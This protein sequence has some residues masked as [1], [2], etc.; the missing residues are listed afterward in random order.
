MPATA[1]IFFDFPATVGSACVGLDN[2]VVGF[3]IDPEL[4]AT[5]SQ[6]RPLADRIGLLSTGAPWTP[7]RIR[8]T[9][10]DNDALALFDTDLILDSGFGAAVAASGGDAD[11]CVFVSTDRERRKRAAAAGMLVTPHAVLARALLNGDRL[12]HVRISAPDDA[13]V[14]SL[15]ERVG[16]A[17]AV[18]FH[19]SGEPRP[20]L[21]ALASDEAI[22]EMRTGGL[23]VVALGTPD[24]VET[25]DLYIFRPGRTDAAALSE[26]RDRI[27][28]TASLFHEIDEDWLVGLRAGVD[29]ED[30]HPPCAPHGH[31]LGLQPSR[32]LIPLRAPA[33]AL[34]QRNLSGDEL[35]DLRT[36][37]AGLIQ[38]YLAPWYGGPIHSRH[39][40]HEDNRTAALEMYAR[41]EGILGVGAARTCEF[42]HHYRQLLNVEGE[43]RGKTAPQEVVLVGA[44]LDSTAMDTSGYKAAISAAPGADDDASGVAAVLAIADVLSKMATAHLPR[45]T[46]RF[47]LFNAE[48]VFMG[49][50]FDYARRMKKDPAVQLLAMLQLDMIG[51]RGASTAFE[52]HAMGAKD[53]GGLAKSVVDRSLEL[54]GIVRKA[55]GELCATFEPQMYPMP[56]CETDP[57]HWRSDHRQFLV[58]GWPACLVAEDLFSEIAC[59]TQA[60]NPNYHTDQDLDVDPDYAAEIA[61]AVAG[62]VWMVANG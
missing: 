49:G 3:A 35:K 29:A 24:L 59:G 44:H 14:V 39:A 61:R 18:P 21:Y 16:D 54:A 6:L 1:V 47:V 8:Q 40:Y 60:G 26:F 46:I 43:I 34:P 56:G 20:A 10:A 36:L 58:R 25:T 4:D 30:F 41:L 45:R 12:H 33:T 7:A 31:T 17:A 22:G 9:L 52:I 37:N 57:A 19:V 55:A 13:D 28:H 11:R 15:A 53:F 38:T 27:T 5:I 50:S 32:T 2:S 23:D 42:R 51:Y 48:E 62:A